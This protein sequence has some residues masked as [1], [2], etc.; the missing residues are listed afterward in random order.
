MATVKALNVVCLFPLLSNQNQ[1]LRLKTIFE[2]C[3]RQPKQLLKILQE[4]VI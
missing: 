1:K 2:V 3:N 4:V